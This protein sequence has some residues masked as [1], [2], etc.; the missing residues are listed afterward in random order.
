MAQTNDWLLLGGGLLV[1]VA[2]VIGIDAY[3]K[4]H[5][6]PTTITRTPKTVI[7]TVR[8]TAVHTV[9]HTVVRTVRHTATHTVRQTPH[10]VTRI[11]THT[12][13]RT[14]IRTP[15]RTPVTT[16]RVTTPHVSIPSLTLTVSGSQFRT[17]QVVTI[18]CRASSSITGQGWILQI[19]DLSTGRVKLAQA[20]GSSWTTT[21]TSST[22][23]THQ[24]QALLFHN[25]VAIAHSNT[26]SITWAPAP[27]DTNA[28]YCNGLGQC[29]HLDVTN[30][31]QAG[32]TGW[33]V[34]LQPAPSGFA[35]PVYQYW[36]LPPN[37]AWTSSGGYQAMPDFYLNANLNGT[38]WFTVYARD[39]SAP[40]GEGA[41]ERA[42]YEAK[43]GTHPVQ[44]FT[45]INTTTYPHTAPG[46]VS[47]VGLQS[48][49]SLGQVISLT[50]SASGITNPVYQ[51]WWNAAGAGWQGSG[52][53]G[54]SN[55]YRLA[56]NTPGTW[57]VMVYARPITA[58]QNEDAKER[59]EYEDQSTTYTFTVS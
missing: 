19:R 59:A 39:A 48:S 16:R 15:V 31:T 22:Q 47:L 11:S 30:Y 44:V 8:R 17:N 29:V 2:A 53:Y 50:A 13:T 14:P 54:T 33:M 46:S 5:A 4:A 1:G 3:Q 25:G 43:S 40:S 7:R 26:V 58:P 10:T 41:T 38:W 32:K 21:A 9:G 36:W 49:Y 35:N 28:G 18:T 45:G 27:N 24:F 37:G 42:H 20:Y 52:A 51:F 23:A 34:H 6:V 56:L 12:V 55:S 57:Q